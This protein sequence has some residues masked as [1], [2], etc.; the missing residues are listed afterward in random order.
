MDRNQDQVE[1]MPAGEAQ[2]DGPLGDTRE[3]PDAPANDR[4][5]SF[6]DRV[7][8]AALQIVFLTH[9]AVI[10][11]ALD[12]VALGL[13]IGIMASVLLDLCM[14]ANSLVLS[15]M[16]FAGAK[17]CAALTSLAHAI[18]RSISHRGTP[19]PSRLI[20]MRCELSR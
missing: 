3:N 1:H 9:G 17:V 18:A 4:P 11:A 6:E 15:F 2:F 7:S 19:A 14:G 5:G 13:C 16:R 12:N 8:I 20:N 10:G